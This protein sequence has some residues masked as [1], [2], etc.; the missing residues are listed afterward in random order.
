VRKAEEAKARQRE[1]EE[2]IKVESVAV[3]TVDD[4]EIEQFFSVKEI[5]EI[6]DKVEM[7]VDDFNDIF[8]EAN[9]M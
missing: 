7:D 8:I 3:P 4:E 6:S 9:E 5:N 1:E 2:A